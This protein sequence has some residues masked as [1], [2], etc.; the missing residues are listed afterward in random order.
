MKGTD[1]YY[2]DGVTCMLNDR[3]MPVANLSVGGFFA[4]TE[5]PPAIGDIVTVQL[6]I[7]ERPLVSV[8]GKVAWRNV[9]ERPRVPHLPAGFGLKILRAPFADR[10]EILRVLG[11]AGP[12]A[13]RPRS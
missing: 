7:N 10:M 5:D 9:P 6:R 8:Q 11:E 2:L 12:A 4:A 13:M 1:R 3:E